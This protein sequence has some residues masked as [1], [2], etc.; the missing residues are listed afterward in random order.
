M[1]LVRR[2]TSPTS[3]CR[4]STSSV[5]IRIAG[6]CRLCLQHGAAVTDRCLSRPPQIDPYAQ[7][8]T[9]RRCREI[10]GAGPY[11]SGRSR[12]ARSAH[13]YSVCRNCMSESGARDRPSWC[14]ASPA[15]RVP[16][17]ASRG[18]WRSPEVGPPL[19]T[20]AKTMSSSTSTDQAQHRAMPAPAPSGSCHV[21][22]VATCA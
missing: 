19:H 8:A 10:D 1:R 17:P 22:I 13:S 3:T 7:V 11:G 16:S 12:P 21:R 6:L 5:G 15:A 9:M 18:P 14:R 20:A 4:C 2:V